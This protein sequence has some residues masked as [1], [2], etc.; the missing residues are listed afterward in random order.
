MTA[1]VQHI[2]TQLEFRGIL[3]G[4]QQLQRQSF[5]HERPYC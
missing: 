4:D 3:K 5:T 1:K 2:T